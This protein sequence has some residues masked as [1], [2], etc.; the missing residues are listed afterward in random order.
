MSGDGRL[1]LYDLAAL[2]RRWRQTRTLTL[3]DIA[4]RDG[5]GL[6]DGEVNGFDLM[7]FCQEWAGV[8]RDV[9]ET[10]NLESLP[11]LKSGFPFWKA[12]SS[13]SR[14]G[15]YCA[16]AGPIDDG[17][18][19]ALMLSARCR[20]GR[21]TFWR[22][23]SSERNY[24]VL[25]FLIDREVVA[26]WSGELDWERVS[27]PVKEGSRMFAWEYTKDDYSAGGD[28]TAWID[29]VLFPAP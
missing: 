9:F 16:Q 15:S 21:I 22:K 1:D 5:L 25:R 23:V 26:E 3:A 11:W 29:D 12:V 10:G 19:T 17:G 2:G 13:Q 20:A 14:S 7:A 6:P 18:R 24:D 28:D 8:V 4:G 27:F